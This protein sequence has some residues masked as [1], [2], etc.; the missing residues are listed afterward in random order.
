MRVWLKSSKSVHDLIVEDIE[1][2]E[3]SVENFMIL[4]FFYNEGTHTIQKISKQLSIPSGSII[5]VVN[6][7]AEREYVKCEQSSRDRCSS[8]VIL[9]EK[10]QTLFK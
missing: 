7:L 9:S 1:I 2:H 8:N 5:Y 4:E 3:L 10:G 6:K